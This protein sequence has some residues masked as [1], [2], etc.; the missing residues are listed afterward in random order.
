YFAGNFMSQKIAVI[1][2]S[3][4]FPGSET[5]DQFWNNL[6]QNKDCRSLATERQMGRDPKA[7]LG[8]PGDDDSFYCIHGGYINDFKMNA[9]DLSIAEERL[10]TMDD[11]H[12]WSLYVAREA[13]RDSGYLKKKRPDNTGVILGNL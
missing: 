8:K 4:L 1:G 10:Q 12:L 11:V 13:L 6:E 7:F 2:L 3:G 5:L 9:D